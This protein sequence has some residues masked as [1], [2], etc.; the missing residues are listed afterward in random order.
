MAMLPAQPQAQALLFHQA[1]MM[2]PLMGS[3]ATCGVL[4][5]RGADDSKQFA[6]QKQRGGYG[7]A[8]HDCAD[9][10]QSPEDALMKRER[11]ARCR[12]ARMELTEAARIEMHLQN[13]NVK[14]APGSVGMPSIVS[15]LS[16]GPVE[17]RERTE[18]GPLQTCTRPLG[19]DGEPVYEFGN[20]L[21]GGVCVYF[22]KGYC[23]LGS[24]CRYVHDNTDAG[25]MVKIT[26]MPYTATYPQ[27]TEF[28]APLEV[29]PGGVTFL[30][31]AD[32]VPTGSA[33]VE[34][35]DRHAALVAVGKDRGY[36]G[37]G[38]YVLIFAS[39]KKERDWYMQ[40]PQAVAQQRLA[41]R[42][43]H[44]ANPRNPHADNQR[45]G[46]HG[47]ANSHGGSHGTV[48]PRIV[49]VVRQGA[50]QQA[51]P[52]TP[53]T[54]PVYAPQYDH[55]A[56]RLAEQQRVI[57]EQAK[58]IQQQQQILLLQQ[59]QRSPGSMYSAASTPCASALS[60]TPY[61]AN[62]SEVPM[63]SPLTGPARS[64][65]PNFDHDDS[66]S[67]LSDSPQ[68]PNRVPSPHSLGQG[69]TP[70]GACS[71]ADPSEE[72]EVGAADDMPALLADDEEDL[73]PAC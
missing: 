68:Q 18:Q 65:L 4:S 46:G 59:L 71:S 22:M 30:R 33:F 51:F 27:V 50:Q 9:P 2:Q 63:V 60:R 3:T 26:G 11:W 32:G 55:L 36:F 21:P 1:M 17:R 40:N 8:E 58:Q 28:F 10:N 15:T 35:R 73:E 49:R 7:C 64:L 25:C 69:T 31:G 16:S 62:G 5:D 52:G 37:S 42:V 72:F 57:Q 29:A 43:K 41:R 53:E 45:Q 6:M 70:S 39:S 56:D 20:G 14:R 13:L 54:A 23:S 12:I 66:L 34:F 61:S 48:G 67:F 47:C 44:A 19:P 38:R 24:R